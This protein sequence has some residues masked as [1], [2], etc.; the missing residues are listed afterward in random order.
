LKKQ[1][2]EE[3]V[4]FNDVFIRL[5]YDNSIVWNEYLILHNCD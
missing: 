2:N 4:D 3:Y 1:S 5:S